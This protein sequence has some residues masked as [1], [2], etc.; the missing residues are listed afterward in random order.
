MGL[1]G[2]KTN[3]AWGHERDGNKAEEVRNTRKPGNQGEA[4]LPTMAYNGRWVL[5]LMIKTSSNP[6]SWRRA[7][8]VLAPATLP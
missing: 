4:A 1:W 8:A 3:D 5:R 7:M 6:W 2:W